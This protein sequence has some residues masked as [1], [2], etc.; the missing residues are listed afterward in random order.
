M[1]VMFYSRR[2]ARAEEV[3]VNIAMFLD[4]FNNLWLPKSFEAKFHFSLHI[5]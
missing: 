4:R 5:K 1:N 2:R 3:L